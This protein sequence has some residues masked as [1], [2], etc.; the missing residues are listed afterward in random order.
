MGK[1]KAGSADRRIEALATHFVTTATLPR[2][3]NLTIPTKINL[4]KTDLRLTVIASQLI[5]SYSKLKL[6]VVV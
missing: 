2:V 6:L 3:L 1:L 5:T 4:L